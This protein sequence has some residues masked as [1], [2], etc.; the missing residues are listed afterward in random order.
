VLMQEHL[1]RE[2]LRTQPPAA[3][4]AEEIRSPAIAEEWGGATYKRDR[5]RLI[6]G[7]AERF[8]RTWDRGLCVQWRRWQAAVDRDRL[9]V[10]RVMAILCDAAEMI[11][12]IRE[13]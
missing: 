9:A 5:D 11:P 7:S 6:L 8:A 4:A 10:E 12:S 3:D 13:G 2:G 1:N